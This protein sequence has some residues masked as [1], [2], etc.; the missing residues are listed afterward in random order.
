M[1]RF[2]YL[3]D[4]DPAETGAWLPGVPAQDIETDD[5]GIIAACRA[6]PGL[7]AEAGESASPAA[8]VGDGVPPAPEPTAP[9]TAATGPAESAPPVPPTEEG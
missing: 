1:T 3:P 5:P 9:Q 8:E 4:A 7:Y 2:H 6:A